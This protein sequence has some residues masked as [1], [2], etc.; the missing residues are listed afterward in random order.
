MGS[1]LRTVILA[2]SVLYE[3]IG[4]AC[5]KLSLALS[6]SYDKESVS[7]KVPQDED[8]LIVNLLIERIREIQ[9]EL[10]RHEPAVAAQ[11]VS[12]SRLSRMRPVIQ[13]FKN[14]ANYFRE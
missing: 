10:P 11:P 7:E 13:H 6:H 3:L 2:S 1:T 5:A 4:P 12:N 9:T 8:K 14:N